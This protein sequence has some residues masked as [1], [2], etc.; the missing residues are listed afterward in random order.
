MSFCFWD[1]APYFS[2][3]CHS[4]SLGTG[5]VICTCSFDTGCI[6][7]MYRACRDMLPSGFERCAPYFRS[8]F[9]G[10][11]MDDS[12]QRIWWWRPV[13]SSTSRRKYLSVF[14]IWQYFNLASLASLRSAPGRHMYDLFCFS[15]RQSMPS[16][17][18]SFYVGSWQTSAQ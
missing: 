13:M 1:T 5:A 11:P 10:Q 2:K 8:P 4:L 17:S 9:M 12:W 16:R 15:L 18:F 3:L 6:N 7:S 14:P